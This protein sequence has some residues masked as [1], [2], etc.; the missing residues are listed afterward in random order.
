VNSG[1]EREREREREDSTLMTKNL[2]NTPLLNTMA[3]GS[4]FSTYSL[5]EDTNIQFMPSN[6]RD[7]ESL[8]HAQ[9]L[10]SYVGNQ[11][12]LVV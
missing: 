7:E 1:R 10:W 12:I 6:S 5:E 3:L 9:T 11:N 8:L 2:P 4:N